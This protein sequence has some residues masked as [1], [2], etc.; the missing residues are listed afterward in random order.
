MFL[1]QSGA[2]GQAAERLIRA[3]LAPGL[4]VHTGYPYSD[5][6]YEKRL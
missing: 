3:L 6:L 1:E 4:R 2:A 5:V